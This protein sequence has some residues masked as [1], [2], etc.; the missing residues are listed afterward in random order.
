MARS[1]VRSRLA[2][3]AFARCA[4]YGLASPVH[5]L[6]SE[7]RLPRRSPLRR[8][9]ADAIKSSPLFFKTH[10]TPM[11]YV[12]IL[13]SVEG[14]I[15]MLASLMTYGLASTNTMPAKCTPQNTSPGPCKRMLPFQTKQKLLL[16]SAILNLR[17][18]EHLQRSGCKSRHTS[19]ATGAVPSRRQLRRGEILWRRPG[20]GR[21]R[22]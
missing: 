6:R 16:L 8:S 12:Y 9:R 18:E 14:N 5:P 20:A 1:S 15:S 17:Q 7:R 10:P 2:P 19:F 3:P 11:K 21:I 13:H 22:A 4:S